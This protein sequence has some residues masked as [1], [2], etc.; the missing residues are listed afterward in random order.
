MTDDEQFAPGGVHEDDDAT[1]VLDV[2]VPRLL[3]GVRADRAI[4]MLT[5]MTR[6][7]SSALVA[8]GA[9]NLDGFTMSKGSPAIGYPL[10]VHDQRIDK[11]P[12]DA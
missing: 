3:D 11:C 10:P 12:L 7:A 1:D 8:S 4:S 2:E 5:G 9:A 6:S